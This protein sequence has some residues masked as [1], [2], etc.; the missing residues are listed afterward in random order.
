[1]SHLRQPVQHSRSLL[2]HVLPKCWGIFSWLAQK[3]GCTHMLAMCILLV[4]MLPV[5]AEEVRVAVAANFTAPMQRIAPD[6]EATTG[7]RLV[8]SY[9]STGKFYAQIR[10]GAPYDILLSADEAT[11]RKL[12]SEGLAATGSNFTYAI[13]KLALWSALS[14]RVDQQGKV[15]NGNQFT[16]IAIVNPRLAPYGAAAVET[17]RK[18]GVYESLQGKIVQG[19]N[20]T[21]VYQFI[22]SG[23]AE[24]GFIALSQIYHNGRYA[25]GSYWLVPEKLYPPLRQN[26]VVLTRGANN[27]GATD[28]INHLKSPK[29]KSVIQSFGYAS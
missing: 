14:E 29:T 3:P 23:N 12:E 11:P 1:M 16:H 15:L 2:V 9:G 4:W 20:L 22:A 19:E 25:N 5:M 21:Q 8:I 24:L 6:F 10:N 26:A 28:F 13:G 17:M 18:L 27:P 7:H